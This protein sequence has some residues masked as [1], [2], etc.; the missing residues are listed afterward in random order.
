MKTIQE[1]E[2][3]Q[4]EIKARF[5]EINT[6]HAGARMS[7]EAA[8]E[9][10]RLREEYQANDE[11]LD[12]MR[13]RE[14]TVRALAARP[15]H[16]ERGADFNIQPERVARDIFDMAAVRQA[17][18]GFEDETRMLMDNAR[19]A[20][21]QMH[22]PHEDANREHT[23]AHIERL[24]V[25]FS[26]DGQDQ[27]F[28]RHV[29]TAGSPTYKRAF[30]KTI[31]GKML[32]T[33][34]QRSMSLTGAS[35]GYAVP[36][37]LDPTII[38]TSNY[39]I[40]PWRQISRVE[41]ITGNTW[42]GVSAGAVTASRDAELEEVSD[43]SPTLAQPTAVVTKAQAFIP[44]SMEL[45]MDWGSF[46]SEVAR[47][48]QDAKD[49]EE[50]TAFATGGGTGVN[51]QGVLTG[52][53]G[54]IAA[55]TAAFAVAHAY[56]L[57]EGLDARFRPN[58][59]F[60]A[61]LVQYNRIRQLDTAGGASLWVPNLTLGVSTPSNGQTNY[62]FLGKPAYESS[63]MATALT[64]ASKL[65]IFGDFRYFLIVD[66]IGMQVEVIP[67][68][69]GQTNQ[70]PIGARGLLAYWRNTSKVLSASALDRKS[71]V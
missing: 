65:M 36:V 31:V 24:L 49:V 46:E 67:H 32:T 64:A 8:N 19:R 59:T 69:F 42:N 39:T 22:F 51:P 70:R 4:K 2:D 68:L 23:Q 13:A 44:F 71:V 21:E 16:R 48:I 35:G 63:V 12:E 45:E 47:L 66:R 54:T 53:T 61:N 37:T 52:A 9:W 50:S 26:A 7:E 57:L 34:E 6:E 41:S 38:P 43:D 33:D 28:A 55:G 18:T 14:E 1:F 20:I 56:A 17:S 11:I 27:A 10:E 60:V 58:A 15:E 29:L 62:T 5:E 25:K 40:N 3:R 30:A